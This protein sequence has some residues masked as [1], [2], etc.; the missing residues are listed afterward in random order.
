M[1][2]FPS[3]TSQSQSHTEDLQNRFFRYALERVIRTVR[4]EDLPDPDTMYSLLGALCE[5]L[6]E[7]NAI[8]PRHLAL[9]L[10]VSERYVRHLLEILVVGYGVPIGSYSRTTG[11]WIIMNED[12]RSRVL[13]DLYSR[14]NAID[15]R[16]NSIALAKLPPSLDFKPTQPQ[17]FMSEE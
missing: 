12:E 10:G 14:R 8:T 17:L 1:T 6:G 16:I 2:S 13:K 11:R 9:T 7:D 3:N 15:A 4:T 5:H